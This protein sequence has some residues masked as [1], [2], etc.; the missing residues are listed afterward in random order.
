MKVMCDCE[1]NNVVLDCSHDIDDKCQH[2]IRTKT[3]DNMKKLLSLLILNGTPKWLEIGA[4]IEKKDLNIVTWFWFGFIN[5]TIMP[6]HND[7]ILRLAK[8]A[9]LG[10]IIVE[11]RIN[12]GIT[13]AQEMVIRDKKC[14]T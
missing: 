11:T 2:L 6:S 10:C 9:F 13:T 14:Q 7:S 1:A 3:L 5:N 12:L 8:A 4:L